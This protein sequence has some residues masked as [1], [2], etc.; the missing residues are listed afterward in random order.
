MRHPLPTLPRLVA[1]GL[2]AALAAVATAPAQ[3][4]TSSDGTLDA[5]HPAV[6]VLADPAYAALAAALAA[7]PG[8][9]GLAPDL[10]GAPRIVALFEGPAPAVLPTDLVPSGWALEAYGAIR[11]ERLELVVDELEE[12]AAPLAHG[13]PLPEDSL[14][15]GPGSTLLVNFFDPVENGNFIGICTAAFVFRDRATGKLFLGAAGHCFMGTTFASTH[16]DDADWDP[17]N[18][19]RVRA[20][21]GNCIGGG[22][23]LLSG[24][25][26]VYPGTTRD[27]GVGATKLVYARQ[28]IAGADVGND[29]GIVEIPAELCPEIRTDMPVWNGPAT[30][31]ISR[32]VQAGDLVAH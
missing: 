25:L 9:A 2:L 5:D 3:S 31:D 18:T 11:Y 14:G 8:F 10:D 4:I 27:L 12:L 22:S 17:A 16:G 30:A 28:T 32:R 15:M 7:E 13:A 21:V 1:C 23:G 29:F 24:A 26:G 20:C 6:A 19:T